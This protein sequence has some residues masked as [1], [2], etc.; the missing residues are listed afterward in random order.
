MQEYRCIK[1]DAKCFTVWHD[2]MSF[3][4]VCDA[5]GHLSSLRLRVLYSFGKKKVSPE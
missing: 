1:C 2:D 5:C 3:V 4:L